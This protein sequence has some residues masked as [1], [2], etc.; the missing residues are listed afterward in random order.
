[1][2]AKVYKAYQQN[3]NREKPSIVLIGDST[4]DHGVDE[5]YLSDLTNKRYLQTGPAWFRLCGL[6]SALEEQYNQCAPQTRPGRD[7]LSWHDAY[8]PGIPHNWHVSGAA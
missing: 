6:V 8:H 3:I 1:M 7:L 4:L 2:N 5:K